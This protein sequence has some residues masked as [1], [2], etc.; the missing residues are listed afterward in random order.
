MR[1]LSCVCLMAMSG[2]LVYAEPAYPDGYQEYCD[3]TGHCEL[4][5]YYTGTDGVVY[6]WHGGVWIGPS[7]P[8]YN[9]Y[10]Y[11]RGYSWHSRYYYH[12]R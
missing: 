8:Y 4:V 12:H 1:L 11:Y 2:C 7:H 9:H 10:W 6:Y 5:R 3:D